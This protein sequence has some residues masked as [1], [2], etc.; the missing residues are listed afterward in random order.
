MIP[1]KRQPR[2]WRGEP[3]VLRAWR[4]TLAPPTLAE[5]ARRLGVS[6][7]QMSR[8]EHGLRRIDP[9]RVK[10]FAAITGIPRELLRP[11]I[12]EQPSHP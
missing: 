12:F 9:Q 8:Y 5:A 2:P 10:H 1:D 4:L 7:P 6:V 3:T 11:D